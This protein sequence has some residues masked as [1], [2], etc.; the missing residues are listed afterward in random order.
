MI[1]NQLRL[2]RGVSTHPIAG[3]AAINTGLISSDIAALGG[4]KESGPGCERSKYGIEEYLELK[5]ICFGVLA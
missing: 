1:A 4:I 5:Y 3:M 2:Q